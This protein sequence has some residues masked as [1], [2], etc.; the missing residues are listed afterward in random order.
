[1]GKAITEA[2]AISNHLVRHKQL[3]LLP[4]PEPQGILIK[5]AVQSGVAECQS[6]QISTKKIFCHLF[7]NLLW[8]FGE[9]THDG[10]AQNFS[11]IVPSMI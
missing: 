1:M 4:H 8:K 9:E 5:G 10:R 6:S 2:L 3:L 7:K 11:I